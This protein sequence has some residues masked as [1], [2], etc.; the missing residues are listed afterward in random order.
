[1]WMRRVLIRSRTACLI[2]VGMVLT[3]SVRADAPTM[4]T[5]DSVRVGTLP[6]G[7][8]ALS[9]ENAAPG[10]WQVVK[11][12]EKAALAQIDVGGPGYRLAVL[13][14]P[15]LAD[16]RA[17]TTLHMGPGDRAAG[18][19]W[20]V[21]DAGTYYAARLDLAQNEFVLYKFVRGNRVRLSRLSN[22]RLSDSDWHEL[23]IE[24]KGEQIRVWLNGIP[25]ASERDDALPEAGMV[26][27]WM[28]ADSTAQ[29][30]RLWY[31]PARG[32]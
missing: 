18:I 12:G 28:P 8:K 25:V 26:G 32:D 27:L 29:F 31:Q 24:H 3:V 1:M 13:D 7:F 11:I 17:G 22:L 6:P 19:A 16:L 30:K 2:G 14:A 5:F 10:R 21:H 20:R 9:S 23:T 15:K 4:I